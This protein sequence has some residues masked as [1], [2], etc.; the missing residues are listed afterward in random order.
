MIFLKDKF[1]CIFIQQET[2][3][4]DLTAE[5]PSP[6]EEPA[7]Q[8]LATTDEQVPATSVGAVTAGEPAPAGQVPATTDEQ[9]ITTAGELTLALPAG[10]TTEDEPVEAMDVAH[11]EVFFYIYSLCLWF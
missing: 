8:T 1:K 3:A 5:A 4:V 2:E 7:A 9:A 11:E 6:T 10:S